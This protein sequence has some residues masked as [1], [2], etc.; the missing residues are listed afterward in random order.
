MSEKMSATSLENMA[1]AAGSEAY[2]L[3]GMQTRELAL[4]GLRTEPDPDKMF[5]ADVLFNAETVLD[6]LHAH[7]RDP[8][9]RTV[10][11]RIW[12]DKFEKRG[13]AP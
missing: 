11:A 12:A 10:L 2:R 8:A 13:D 6:W 1:A 9:V 3:R 4:Y 5:V 7:R